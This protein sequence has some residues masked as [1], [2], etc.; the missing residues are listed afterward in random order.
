[1]NKCSL[2]EKH[3]QCPPLEHSDPREVLILLLLYGL[4][5]RNQRTISNYD[6]HQLV[7]ASQRN[8]SSPFRYF[9][10]DIPLSYSMDLR[11][12]V[13]ILNHK[14]RLSEFVVVQEGVFPRHEYKLSFIGRALAI[15]LHRR[16]RLEKPV[17]L[18]ELNKKLDSFLNSHESGRT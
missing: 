3:P 17:L 16:L 5:K 11:N 15:S 18:E 8:F 13:R 2:Q 12:Y 7:K 9:K 14:R 10:N 1:M 4:E 6:L